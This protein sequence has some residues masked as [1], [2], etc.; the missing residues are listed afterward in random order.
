MKSTTLL[1]PTRF[2]K[3]LTFIKDVLVLA[4]HTS[5]SEANAKNEYSLAPSSTVIQAGHLPP[6]TAFSSTESHPP[7][8]IA[9]HEQSSRDSLSDTIAVLKPMPRMND[10]SADIRRYSSQ[11]SHT[12]H[13]LLFHTLTISFE[14]H[15][16]LPTTKESILYHVV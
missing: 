5:F 12:Q 15:T 13:S 14:H 16:L 6:K 7:L 10:P 11:A 3:G 8:N 2:P 4:L 9:L 1:S